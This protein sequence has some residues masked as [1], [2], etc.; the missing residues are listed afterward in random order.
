MEGDVET[1]SLH[2]PDDPL[3]LRILV[4]ELNV[5]KAFTVARDTL[6]WDV[7]QQ[8]LSALPKELKESFNYGLFN[9]PENG[10]AG[11]FLDEERRIGDYSFPSSEGYLEVSD[12]HQS[13]LH[14]IDPHRSNPHRSDPHR[15]DLHRSD[16]HRSDPRF[17]DDSNV[18]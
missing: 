7:K 14:Q 5:Q 6:V 15:S 13:D 1:S 2:G 18:A 12:S 11:K 10:R 17:P 3:R 8:C 4:P 16:L 9:P